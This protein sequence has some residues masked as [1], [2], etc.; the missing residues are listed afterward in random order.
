MTVGSVN[1]YSVNFFETLMYSSCCLSLNNLLI[2]K[3][4]HA[5]KYRDLFKP[6]LLNSFLVGGFYL[7]LIAP[8]AMVTGV[9]ALAT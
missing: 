9:V 7:W 3:V 8:G 5:K 2:L 4:N 1:A 6:S